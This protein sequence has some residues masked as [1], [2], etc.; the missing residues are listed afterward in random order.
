MFTVVKDKQN[1]LV[2]QKISEDGLRRTVCLFNQSQ[3]IDNR[4]RYERWIR[5]QR[6]LD[7]AYAIKVVIKQCRANFNREAGFANA[8]HSDQCNQ[9]I[10]IDEIFD[11]FLIFF[12]PNEA[13]EL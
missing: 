1:L 12:T 9:S 13:G 11:F 10:L 5:Q 8:A 2:F 7:Q 3:R 4:L 6:E